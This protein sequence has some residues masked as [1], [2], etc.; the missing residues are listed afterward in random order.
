MPSFSDSS[1]AILSS[2][3][4]GFSRAIWRTSSRIFFGSAGR[5][6]L[7][8]LHRQNILNAVRCH[9]RNVS[10]FTITNASRQSKSR[11]KATIV[12]RIAAVVFRGLALRSWNRA[13]CLRRKRFSA[14]RAARDEKNNPMNVSNSAFYKDLQALR[15]DPNRSDRIFAD[16]DLRRFA[17]STQWASSHATNRIASGKSAITSCLCN[18][19]FRER[20]RFVG[21]RCRGPVLPSRFC[22]P[23][24]AQPSP[25][26]WVFGVARLPALTYLGLVKLVK[27][28]ALVR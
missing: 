2:P 16:P 15:L 23:P 11:P 18:A 28:L 1:S 7:R 20:V 5:P 14:I 4:V 21:L 22:R 13:S 17:P 27:R 25:P 3:H 9:L 19:S 12:A 6:R 24:L 26:S 10:G 8:D